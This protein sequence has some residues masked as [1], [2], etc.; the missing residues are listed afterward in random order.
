MT[1]DGAIDSSGLFRLDRQVAL[2]TG[3][4]S[5]LG[6]RF[7]R[8]LHGAG[9][10][11]AVVARRTGPLHELA[12]ALPNTL[13]VAA[14]LADPE[15]PARVVEHVVERFGRVDLLVN[16]AGV[17]QT[18]DALSEPISGVGGVL[19]VNV[20]AGLDLARLCVPH[21]RSAGGGRIVFVTS[22]L[23]LVGC[24]QTQPSYAASK[25][26]LISLTRELAAQ[27]APWKIRVN[28][29]A[30]GWFNTGL[31]AEMFDDE[32]AQ[33]WMARSTPLGRPGE[34]HEL[35]GALLFLASEASCFVTG[36]TMVV[37]GGWTAI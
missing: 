33:R 20:V 17:S 35:D 5:G 36:Q 11:V 18:G 37:D 12:A 6:H 24:G 16:N 3:A 4:S 14:D 1:A 26:A 22:M 10:S 13:V 34:D 32:K 25:G 7:A 28:A 15:A 9:A 21:M 31:T 23:G 19:Q 30:P 8:L 27:W 29:L 2:V